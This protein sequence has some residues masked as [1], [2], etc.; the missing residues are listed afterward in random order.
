MAEVFA[1]MVSLIMIA[2]FTQNAVFDRALDANVAIYASR[3]TSHIMGFAICITV[4]TTLAS[5]A[6][7]PFDLMLLPS[8][9]GYLFMPLIYTGIV[10][11]LYLLGL[12]ILWRVFPKVFYKVKKYAHL[13]VFNC[14]VFG[15]LFL[16]YNYGKGF[17]G[18]VGYG[19]GTGAGFFL[20]CFLLNVAHERLNSEKIPK[21]FRGY[22]ITLVFIG[23]ISLALNVLVG[24][25]AEF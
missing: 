20:A 25:T 22:P 17:A 4:M 21:V 2:I 6:A 5:A 19:F 23:I 12:F 24:Y 11:V 16:N 8:K 18:Y 14:A 9:Y 7:Y 1:R 13:A 10:S 3:K 15:A